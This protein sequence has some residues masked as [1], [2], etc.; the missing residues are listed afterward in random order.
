LR[1]AALVGPTAVGK[2]KI[3]EEVI[4]RDDR[5]VFISCDSRKVYRG[6]DIGTNKPKSPLCRF[7]KL[8]DI[9]EPDQSF[10]AREF[11]RMAKREVVS[12]LSSGRIPLVVGG[13]PL[14]YRALFFGLFEAPPPDPEIRRHLLD[15]CKKEG[16]EAL[17]AELKR[18]DGETAFK[19]RP[20]DWIRITRALE[21]YYQVG[22]PISKLRREKAPK[23]LPRPITFGLKRDR[24]D[25]YR[26]INMRVDRMMEEGL[27]EEVREILKRGY[28]PDSPGLRTIGYEELVRH[29]KGELSLSEAVRLIKKRTRIY[30]RKQMYFFRNLGPIR[31]IRLPDEDPVEEILRIGRKLFF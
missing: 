22:I 30:S 6:L 28:K 15:R 10:N 2:S 17:F 29:L 25:L 24:R 26:R 14:Y 27:L 20:K 31:W 8:I 1:I 4:E 5:F 9:R 18:I 12:A 11:A 13:T 16:V 21:V 23:N 19:L 7:F 3:L